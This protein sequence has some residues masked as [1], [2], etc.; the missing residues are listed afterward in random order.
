MPDIPDISTD[1]I[2]ISDVNIPEV[3]DWIVNP[4]T[5]L[6]PSVPVT[7]QVGIPIVDVPGCVE[8]HESNNNSNTVGVDDENG[9]VTYCDAGM[10][11][12]YPLDYDT[13]KMDFTYENSSPT[14][15]SYKAT[16]SRHT[17]DP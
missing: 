16:R 6:P 12:F 7:S 14:C 4:P 8:A 5:A 1:N 11:S 9:L 3:R 2:N 10:P 17:R 13:N 15:V